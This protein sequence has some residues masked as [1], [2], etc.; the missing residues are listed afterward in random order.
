MNKIGPATQRMLQDQAHWLVAQTYQA[1]AHPT[2]LAILST[3]EAGPRTVTHLA[4][5]LGLPVSC[6]SRHLRV[7]RE[8]MLVTPHRLG[9]TV[10]YRVSD[11]RIM[12]IIELLRLAPAHPT[13]RG[14]SLSS[15]QEMK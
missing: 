1:L 13:R 15:S 14:A 3:L 6:V 7:L 10:A 12:H 11:S 2:R 9:S 5:T 4:D 8:T